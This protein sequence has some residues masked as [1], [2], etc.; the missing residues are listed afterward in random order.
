MAVSLN[1]NNFG[2]LVDYFGG[3][4]DL[5][6]GLVRVLYNLSFIEDPTRIIRAVRFEQRYKI[7][8][9]PQT[10][11]LLKDAVQQQVL[12]KVSNDRLWDELSHIMMEPEAGKMLARLDAL[13]IWPQVLPGVTFW[14]V[15]P[16]LK[17]LHKSIARLEDWG[18]GI[19]GDPWLPY[20]IAILHWSDR[21][22]AESICSKYS[23]SRRQTEKVMATL[24]CWKEVMAALSDSSQTRISGLAGVIL[25]LPREAYPLLLTVMDE[26]HLKQRLKTVLNTIKESR[27]SINGNYIKKLGYKP[28]PVY[29]DALNGLWKAKMD[30]LV[31]SEEEE[32]EF[33]QDFLRKAEG[34]L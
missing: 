24:G 1:E 10:L 8:I 13:H 12:L 19:E 29:R 14:E 17:G 6:Y 2:E 16:V 18:F 27:P 31:S 30:G 9:E 7:N 23:L 5:H 34:E 22:V 32:R 25:K 26:K 33:I 28:G 11:K 15:Q 4:D 21:E 20:I 3:R